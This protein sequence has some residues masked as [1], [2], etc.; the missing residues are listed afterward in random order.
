MGKPTD[1][2]PFPITLTQTLK[3]GPKVDRDPM[4]SASSCALP[5]IGRRSPQNGQI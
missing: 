2:H 5:S 3:R 4:I 1:R